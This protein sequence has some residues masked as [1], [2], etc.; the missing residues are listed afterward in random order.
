MFGKRMT[1]LLIEAAKCFDDGRSPFE[2]SWLSENNV[3]LDECMALSHYI[4]IILR[5][6]ALASKSVQ[7][8]ILFISARNM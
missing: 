5:G 6:A 8:E 1:H 7:G 4:G 2:N 3:T